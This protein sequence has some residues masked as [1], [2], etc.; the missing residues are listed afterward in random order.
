L[1]IKRA[2]RV[3][4]RMSLRP[5]HDDPSRDI[6]PAD[7][8]ALRGFA[9]FLDRAIPIP[10]TRW[11]VGA[12]ALAGLVPGIGDLLGAGASLWIVASAL[13]HRVSPLVTLRML[14]N[15]GVDTVVGAVPLLGD[16]FD[17][18][19]ESNVRNVELIV[20]HR[21]RSRP[22]RTLREAGAAALALILGTLA[23]LIAAVA[24]ATVLIRRL[25]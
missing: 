1:S 8:Q 9:H 21:D 16:I 14:W 4:V 12:D 24:A 15:V 13:R 11:H 3:W 10:G 18:A 7:L 5:Q 20:K 23:L 19:W 6:L 2:G 17:A 25:A 22:P